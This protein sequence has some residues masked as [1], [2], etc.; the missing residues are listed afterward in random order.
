MIYIVTEIRRDGDVILHEG[1]RDVSAAINALF[2]LAEGKGFEET[3]DENGH[4]VLVT[5]DVTLSVR[6]VPCFD[7]E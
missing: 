4:M 6:E 1:F 3:Q 5:D 2:Q 7:L